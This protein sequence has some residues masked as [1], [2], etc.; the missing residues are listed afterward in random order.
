MNEVKQTPYADC[1]FSDS[2]E[3]SSNKFKSYFEI[4]DRPDKI[5]SRPC[6]I[7]ENTPENVEK[8]GV[9][10]RFVGIRR[11]DEEALTYLSYYGYIDEEF[12][13]LS[14]NVHGEWAY[15]EKYWR[16]C[17]LKLGLLVGLESSF[18][19]SLSKPV[20]DKRH[21]YIQFC[22][23][24]YKSVHRFLGK[25]VSFC[26]HHQLLFQNRK[27]CI[28]PHFENGKAVKGVAHTYTFP[29]AM[30]KRMGDLST[31]KIV[32]IHN[33]GLHET[34]EAK[35]KRLQKEREE[36]ELEKDAAIGILP[37]MDA[38]AKQ[39]K[40][41][42]HNENFEEIVSNAAEIYAP[43][44]QQIS[45]Q[46]IKSEFEPLHNL[47]EAF[48]RDSI[49][50]W[51][52][53]GKTDKA[54][55]LSRSPIVGKI[56]H[57]L[58]NTS[59]LQR[60]QSKLYGEDVVE[61]DLKSHHPHLISQH[62]QHF[63]HDNPQGRDEL[64]IWNEWLETGDFYT[65]LLKYLK[66]ND[67]LV[68]YAL[69]GV[70]RKQFKVIFQQ[71]LS[72]KCPFD[73]RAVRYAIKN[74]LPSFYKE[75]LINHS[76]GHSF[77]RRLQRIEAG[78]VDKLIL[79]AIKKNIP[80]IPFYDSFIVRERD[81]QDVRRFLWADTTKTEKVRDELLYKADGAGD[82]K[83][84]GDAKKSFC[85]NKEEVENT[86]ANVEEDQPKDFLREIVN[87]AMDV[88]DMAEDSFQFIQQLAQKSKDSFVEKFEEVEEE[89]YVG[90]ETLM[91]G[92]IQ[93]DF[94]SGYE[95]WKPRDVFL[96]ELHRN[97]ATEQRKIG[98]KVL[99]IKRDKQSVET[100]KK[101]ETPPTKMKGEFSEKFESIH[102]NK[103]PEQKTNDFCDFIPAEIQ[104]FDDVVEYVANSIKDVFKRYGF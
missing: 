102:F 61:I 25:F 38:V 37:N 100:E 7:F 3:R 17:A 68:D 28:L 89:F 82:F 4:K 94:A 80:L 91:N 30:V 77:Q 74:L 87:L 50:N 58:S 32:K 41:K 84:V 103:K 6:E 13:K 44:F 54:I 15:G 63:F 19:Y 14:E 57:S 40:I 18:F 34:P 86:V 42:T 104:S 27:N 98:G 53:A 69:Q 29:K 71:V 52:V 64:F 11:G 8:I 93:R 22:G 49:A 43:D 66:D 76:K 20:R 31:Q 12:I 62:W 23:E 16:D 33:Y 35:E 85:K 67:G 70:D 47:K 2:Y 60:L 26:F 10:E 1:R 5:K 56:S 65:A 96:E 55:K 90:W 92:M 97:R 39:D 83:L 48:L 79:F 75:N 95:N 36:K 81:A 9:V 78:K 45:L 24:F 99:E 72:G 88:G 73:Y 59:K 101:Q 21:F 46:P 51:D